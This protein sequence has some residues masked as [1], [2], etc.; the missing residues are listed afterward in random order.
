MTRPHKEY[1]T[2]YAYFRAAKKGNADSAT[3]TV[4]GATPE[5]AAQIFAQAVN[6][7]D[8]GKKNGKPGSD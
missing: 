5:Q 8:A 1:P 7:Q 6:D 3:C 4:Y 2:V